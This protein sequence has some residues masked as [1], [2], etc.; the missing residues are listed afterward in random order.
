LKDL[1]VSRTS[2]KWGIPVPFDKKHVIY[3]WFDALINYLSGVNYETKTFERYWPA[4]IHLIG[5]DIVWHHTIIWG[6]MLLSTGIKLPKTV[7]VHGF[8]NF[9]GE[10]LSKSTGKTIDPFKLVEKY[11]SDVLR[12]YFLKDIVFGEDGD[13]SEDSL[14]EK[15]NELADKLGNL[16]SRLEGLSEKHGEIA[17]TTT[18]KSLS[19][20]LK[21]KEITNKLDNYELD[22]ALHLIIKFVDECNKYIQENKI[23]ELK[24]KEL[25]KALYTVADSVRRVG[26]LLHPFIPKTSEEILNRLNE[27]EISISRTKE[28]LLKNIKLKKKGFLF[29]K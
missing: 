9:K 23:W 7:L 15:N 29:K 26:I 8:V 16:V 24:G 17:K 14:K 25:N 11:G 21:L 18:D 27:K 10:K 4:D 5:K 22:K 28:G 6:T 19:N 12:Y 3:V 1:S 20:K 13:F 2:L